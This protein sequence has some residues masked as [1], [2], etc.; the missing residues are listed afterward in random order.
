MNL[1]NKGMVASIVFNTIETVTFEQA[2]RIGWEVCAALG[3]PAD[4]PWNEGTEEK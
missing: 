1:T 3:I 2:E 4:E